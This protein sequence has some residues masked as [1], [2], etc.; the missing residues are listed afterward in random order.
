MRTLRSKRTCGSK[1]TLRSK[2][3]VRIHWDYG[4]IRS[5]GTM[6]V[7]EHWAVR[8][9]WEYGLNWSVGILKSMGTLGKNGYIRE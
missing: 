4:N 7:R 2:N 6:V 3:R 9:H 5:I 8:V 1:G